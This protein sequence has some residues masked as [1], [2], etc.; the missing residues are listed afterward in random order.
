MLSRLPPEEV[1]Q[2]LKLMEVTSDKCI[3]LPAASMIHSDQLDMIVQFRQD[4]RK[5]AERV[6]ARIEEEKE[7][8]EEQ[9]P[10]NTKRRSLK[11]KRGMRAGGKAVVWTEPKL[12]EEE[13][14]P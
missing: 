3:A 13:P 14:L 11:P 6:R 5:Q 12:I 4:A 2:A 10:K 9:C 1:R 8:D 7:K